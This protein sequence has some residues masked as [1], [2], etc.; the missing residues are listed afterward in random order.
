MLGV[1]MYKAIGLWNK[2]DRCGSTITSNRKN[3][4]WGQVHR[5]IACTEF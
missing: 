1:L 2:S 5:L 4:R 3:L